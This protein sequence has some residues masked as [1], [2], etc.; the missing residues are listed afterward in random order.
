[1][2]PAI[3]MIFVVAKGV[4]QLA[5]IQQFPSRARCEAVI[6]T[7]GISIGLPRGYRLVCLAKSP[8]T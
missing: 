4:P 1:M 7:S 2:L 5:D 3:Y 6:R 8:L